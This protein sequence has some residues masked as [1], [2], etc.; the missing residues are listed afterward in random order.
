MR[1]LLLGLFFITCPFVAHANGTAFPDTLNVAIHPGRMASVGLE[2]NFGLLEAED[3]ENFTW[4]C[5]ETVLDASSSLTPAYFIGQ[6][7]HLVSTR[8][9]GV[10]IQP[11]FS[12][13]RSTDGCNWD[14][15][16]SLENVNVRDIAFDPSNPAHVLAA[17][18]TGGDTTNGIWASSDGGATWAKTSLDVPERYFRSVRF[19]KADPQRIYASATWFEPSPQAW[20]YVTTNGGAAWSEIPWVFT[21]TSTLQMNVDIVATSA[22]DPLE[23]FA[24]TNGGTDYLLRTT[25]GGTAW[26]EVHKAVGD[27]IRGVTYEAGTGAVWAVSPFAGSWRSTNGI[28]FTEIVGA[29]AVRGISADERGIFVVAN[30]FADPFALGHSTDGGQTFSKLFRFN[31]LQGPRPCPAGSDVAEHCEPLWPALSQLL[32]IGVTPTPTPPAGDDD[33][34]GGGGGCSCSVSSGPLSG[35]PLA[36]LLFLLVAAHRRRLHPR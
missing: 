2:A 6:D 8:S 23:A 19:S 13:F 26:H 27:D 12:V 30:N 16:A 28:D 24:R 7:V 29:P 36:M 18:F 17:T 31:E 22:S 32:G 11:T 4:T 33:D 3:G 10:A 9:L 21:V 25:N 35:G 34:D 15:P 20:L 5:H 14:P 1:R